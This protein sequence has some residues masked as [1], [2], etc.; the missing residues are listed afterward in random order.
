MKIRIR[1]AV[2]ICESLES[3]LCER[4]SGQTARAEVRANSHNIDPIE[5]KVL[6]DNILDLD[7]RK[8][9]PSYASIKDMAD[10]LRSHVTP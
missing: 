6:L 4:M 7:D 10:W 1:R 2:E 8:Y 3:T 5:E 9:A